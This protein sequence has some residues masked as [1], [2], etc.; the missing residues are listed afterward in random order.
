MTKSFSLVDS[1]LVVLGPRHARIVRVRRVEGGEV[2]AERGEPRGRRQA[3][4]GSGG[5]VVTLSQL[6]LLPLLLLAVSAHLVNDQVRPVVVSPLRPVTLLP[7]RL[8]GGSS[9]RK[10]CTE[11][12]L[13]KQLD[14]PF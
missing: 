9:I 1:L 3:V 6:L 10:F 7:P 12:W 11:F 5:A 8:L 13:K 14:T 4:H 2:V